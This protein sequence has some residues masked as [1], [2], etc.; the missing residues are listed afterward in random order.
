MVYYSGVKINKFSKMKKL[1]AW[2]IILF[3]LSIYVVAELYISSIVTYTPQQKDLFLWIDTAICGMFLFE[4]FRGLVCA[5]NKVRYLEINWID[6]VSSIPMIGFL[7]VGRVVKV[8]R[9][10]RVIRSGKMFYAIFSRN[11]PLRALKSLA[12]LIVIL[13]LLFSL[14]IHQLER[15]VNPYFD[16]L[17]ESIWWTIHTTITFGFLQDMAP[18]TSEG[19]IIS[20]VLI[21]LGMVLFGTFIS[22]LTD[23]FVREEDI[24][25]EVKAL[26]KS[27]EELNTKI[28]KLSGLLEE[29]GKKTG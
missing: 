25:E 17:S 23:S 3:I 19:K 11:N 7:R 15:E 9:V 6:F 28:D 21:L 20:L 5:K 14:S 26:K 12:I 18:V 29:N 1:T 16:S 24:K 27:V 2:E 8:I 4:F 22:T 10:L 13:I